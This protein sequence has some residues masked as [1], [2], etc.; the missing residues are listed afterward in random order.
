MI[1]WQGLG[2]L[3]PII[4]ILFWI[5]I[6]MTIGSM[7]SQETFSE[8]FKYFSTI[9]ILLGAVTLW[10]LGRKLNGSEGRTL[11]D[12]TTGETVIL[13]KKH[14]LFFIKMEYWAIP[15]ILLFAPLLF[16]D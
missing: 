13:K 8:Y 9:S 15:L 2:I 5:I 14:T 6:P 4:P 1:I 11:V 16:L 12:E 3:T 7:V 10:F